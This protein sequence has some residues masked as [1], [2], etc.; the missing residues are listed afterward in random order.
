MTENKNRNVF[1]CTTG[2]CDGKSSSPKLD[3]TVLRNSLEKK[4]RTSINQK[5][6]K[7][8]CWSS[9][10]P[11]QTKLERLLFEEKQPKIRSSIFFG[12]SADQMMSFRL[13]VSHGGGGDRGGTSAAV[14]VT[15]A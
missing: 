13:V 9:P 4:M 6:K 1:L 12:P 5:K 8:V 7:R 10:S 11:A 14:S 15:A 2:L 3:C